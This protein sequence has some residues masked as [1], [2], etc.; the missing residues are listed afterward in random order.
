MP[1]VREEESGAARVN[2][3]LLRGWTRMDDVVAVKEFKSLEVVYQQRCSNFFLYIC[4]EIV[5]V[6]PG[7]IVSRI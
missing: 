7:R 3:C 6:R 4:L 1:G 2:N 5:F